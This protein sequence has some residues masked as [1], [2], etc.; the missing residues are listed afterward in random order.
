M[1]PLQESDFAPESASIDITWPLFFLINGV[2]K[3]AGESVSAR[4]CESKESALVSCSKS[5]YQDLS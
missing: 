1:W 2:R 3:M 4:G 5:T